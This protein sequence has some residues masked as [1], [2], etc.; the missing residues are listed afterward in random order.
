MVSGTERLPI[1]Q[2]EL[3]EN[4]D[5]LTIVIPITVSITIYTFC[6]SH[7][8]FSKFP[9]GFIYSPLKWI[10]WKNYLHVILIKEAPTSFVLYAWTKNIWAYGYTRVTKTWNRLTFKH[11]T[12]H[13]H[14]AV[15]TSVLWIL[16]EA[17]TGV[18]FFLQW[19]ILIIY[20]PHVMMCFDAICMLL[21][22][23][24]VKNKMAVPI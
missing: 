21:Y 15:S 18:V 7:F 6:V 11:H 8:F 3:K 10:H 13:S 12:V 24:G 16:H 1:L 14:Y 17:T 22:L 9:S 19:R 23:S 5:I 4:G 2:M 20:R